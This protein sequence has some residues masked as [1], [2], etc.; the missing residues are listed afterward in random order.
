MKGQLWPSL[1]TIRDGLRRNDWQ[2]G[3][4]EGLLGVLVG[5]R[6]RGMRGFRG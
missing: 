1:S 2:G 5:G 4:Y 3:L 6:G